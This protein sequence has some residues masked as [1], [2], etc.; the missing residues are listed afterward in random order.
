M[1]PYIRNGSTALTSTT[2]D[3]SDLGTLP[4]GGTSRQTFKVSLPATV[5]VGDTINFVGWTEG[6]KVGNYTPKRSIA[7]SSCTIANDVTPPTVTIR[8]I[9]GSTTTQAVTTSAGARIIVEASENISFTSTSHAGLV[10]IAGLTVTESVTQVINTSSPGSSDRWVLLIPSTSALPPGSTT[11]DAIALNTVIE[12]NKAGIIDKNGNSPVVDPRAVAGS[13]AAPATISLGGLET[14]A[15]AQTVLKS[16][17][18]KFTAAALG[19]HDGHLGSAWKL[20]VNNQR[21][22]IM[23]TVTIDEANKQIVVL[24]DDGYHTVADISTAYDQNGDAEWVVSTGGSNA[25]TDKV[26]RTLVPATCSIA[27]ATC[28]ESHVTMQLNSTEPI[29]LTAAGLSVTVN[30]LASGYVSAAAITGGDSSVV[31]TTTSL[32]AAGRKLAYAK[33]ITFTSKTAGAGTVSFVVGTATDFN[34]PADT[35][36]SKSSAP[37]SFTL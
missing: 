7:A 8:A 28:G 1:A 12:L 20:I 22:L 34:A 26:S 32:T 10:K 33:V 3:V 36:G 16:G 37:V 9:A 23:P 24:A 19:D 35:G 11:S 6:T 13:D 18:L 25:A 15:S 14:T 29:S 2:V 17:N 27:A 31:G 30:G 21:G 5:A 4:V